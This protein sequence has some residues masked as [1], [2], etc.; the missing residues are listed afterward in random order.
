M[1]QLLPNLPLTV[2]YLPLTSHLAFTVSLL[3]AWLATNC[4]LPLQLCSPVLQHILTRVSRGVGDVSMKKL[5]MTLSTR[6]DRTDKDF[7]ALQEV[8]LAR[9][10]LA[11]HKYYV[12][13]RL[14]TK[15][16]LPWFWR[17]TLCYGPFRERM[18]Y[19]TY[20]FISVS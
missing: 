4:C 8:V 13:F 16:Y 5:L 10:L 14:E 19:S 11:L 6:F 12:S 2:I 20:Y 7:Q 17:V 1:C 3:A 9:R 18:E 15:S